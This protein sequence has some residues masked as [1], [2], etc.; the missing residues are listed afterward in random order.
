[1][2]SAIHG[3]RRAYPE[4]L[5][6]PVEAVLLIARRRFPRRGNGRDLRGMEGSRG[7][8]REPGLE[9]LDFGG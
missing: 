3:V 4:N 8:G 7:N 6:Q 2:A 5:G 1:M 9:R